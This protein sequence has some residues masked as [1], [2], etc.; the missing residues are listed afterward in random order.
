MISVQEL[1]RWVAGLNTSSFVGI[2]EGSLVLVEVRDDEHLT[3]ASIEI[4]GYE[5]D[6]GDAP[7]PSAM[8]VEPARVSAPLE[9]A[10]ISVAD[11]LAMVD[12]SLTRTELSMVRAAIRKSSI[13]DSLGDVVFAVISERRRELTAELRPFTDPDAFTA[14]LGSGP[15]VSVAAERI[16][17]LF[18]AIKEATGLSLIRVR[19]GDAARLCIEDQA[20][21]RLFEIGDT[22]ELWLR[23]DITTPGPTAA[24]IGAPVDDFTHDELTRTGPHD[25]QLP[26][27][28]PRRD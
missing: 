26:E 25:Y 4:G 13:G 8:A 1:H 12:G 19:C 27:P 5:N 28:A 22:L 24:W 14:R 6:T 18:A 9:A 11:L 17:G 10:V 2:D 23:G 20:T 7:Q 16:G 3:G 21:G 15:L